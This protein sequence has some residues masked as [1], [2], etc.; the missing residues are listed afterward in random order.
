MMYNKRMLNPDFLRLLSD[1][2][3]A[4][5]SPNVDRQ[6]ACLPELGCR[7][8]LATLLTVRLRALRQG[9]LTALA[10]AFDEPP[11][12]LDTLLKLVGVQSLAEGFAEAAR[13]MTRDDFRAEYQRLAELYQGLYERL[14][15]IPRAPTEN[16]ADDRHDAS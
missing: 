14:T 3:R 12:E 8:L 5:E 1:L 4:I 7:E 6:I 9:L 11:V 10:H 16:P 2:A 15:K 13:T